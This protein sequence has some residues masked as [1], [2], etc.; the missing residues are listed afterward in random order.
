MIPIY[1]C[2]DHSETLSFIQKI[3]ESYIMI[4]DYDMAIV[5]ASNDPKALLQHRKQEKNLRSI[6]FLDV[7]LQHSDYDGFLLAKELRALDPRGFFIFVTTHEELIFETFKYRLEALN[8]LTKD[9]PERLIR[10]IH[11]CLDDIHQLIEHEQ[12]SLDSYFTV[13]LGDTIQQIPVK[14]IYYFETA[15]RP[16]FLKLCAE[17][18]LIEFRGNLQKIADELGDEFCKIHRSYLVHLKKI[19]HVNYQQ[20]NLEMINEDTCLISRK[21]KKLLKEYF[22]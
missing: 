13:K 4:A 6:Y 18:R 17:N 1:L 12:G 15:D 11:E 14:D 16:H 8:Y 10:M 5:F 20:S 19:K 9:N 3:I 7:D 2:E 21:G 22:N